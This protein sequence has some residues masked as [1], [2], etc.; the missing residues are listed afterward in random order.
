MNYVYKLREKVEFTTAGNVCIGNQCLNPF[1]KSDIQGVSLQ[2]KPAVI[3]ITLTMM[4]IF[5]ELFS[6]FTLSRLKCYDIRKILEEHSISISDTVCNM[7]YILKHGA[8]SSTL[9]GCGL[10][11]I[12]PLLVIIFIFYTKEDNLPY[13]LANHKTYLRFCL[14]FFNI[15]P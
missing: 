11:P 4:K 15:P 12:P 3:I 7:H 9:F 13:H 8:Y 2:Y 10:W 6:G 14:F 5:Y 1:I